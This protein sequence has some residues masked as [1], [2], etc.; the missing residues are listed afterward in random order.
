MFHLEA[1]FFSE[2]ITW[3]SEYSQQGWPAAAQTAAD[4]GISIRCYTKKY[5]NL[6]TCILLIIQ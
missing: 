3:S 1:V 2:I 5:S 6:V 4:H